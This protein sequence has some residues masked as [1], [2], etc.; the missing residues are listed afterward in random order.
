MIVGLIPARGG[1]KRVPRKNI[2]I[3]GGKPLLAWTIEVAKQSKI[4]KLVLSSEDEEILAVAQ[5]YGCETIKRPKKLAMDSTSSIDVV[6]HA[7]SVMSPCKYIVLLQPTSP[8]RTVEDINGCI[9]KCRDACITTYQGKPNGAVYV[10]RAAWFVKH[11]TFNAG[12]VYEM[13]GE[14]SL[15]IDTEEDLQILEGLL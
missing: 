10:A 5:E 15:D 1:S 4:N 13:P 9:D 3:V 6:L 8:L 14:R 7:L 11:K 12:E 2:R